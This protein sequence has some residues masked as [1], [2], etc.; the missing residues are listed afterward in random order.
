[1]FLSR[2]YTKETDGKVKHYCDIL[3]LKLD[4]D[5]SQKPEHIIQLENKRIKKILVTPDGRYLVL[6]GRNQFFVCELESKKLYKFY[7]RYA[8]SCLAIHPKQSFVAVGD[9]QGEIVF[10][11]LFE[12]TKSGKFELTPKPVKT[13][14]HWH[15]KVVGDISFD[16]EGVHMYSGGQESVL[17]VWQL[18]TGRRDFLPRLGAGVLGITKTPDETLL[19]LRCDNNTIKI[20]N[21]RNRLLQVNIEGVNIGNQE[22]LL[23]GLVV[24]PRHS[25][26]VFNGMEG[27]L[28]FYSPHE[29][30]H[31]M[32]VQVGFKNP[33]SSF[34]DIKITQSIV[35][36]VVFSHDANWMVT[37]DCRNDLLHESSV[38]FWEWDGEKQQYILHTQYR[39]SQKSQASYI[40]YHPSENI[41]II[42]DKYG[43]FK[44]WKLEVMKNEDEEEDEVNYRWVCQSVGYYRQ[45]EI[46]SCC[47]SQDGS[48]LA[49]AYGSLVTLWNPRSN[50]FLKVLSYTP[51][52]ETIKQMNFVSNSQYLVVFTKC[53]IL[54]WDIIK[55]QLRWAQVISP[56][57]VAFDPRSSKFAVFSSTSLD[58]EQKESN[59]HGC[60]VIYTPEKPNPVGYWI[61]ATKQVKALAFLPSKDA[62]IDGTKINAPSTLTYLN[63]YDE[64]KFLQEATFTSSVVLSKR[65]KKKHRQKI[66]QLKAAAQQ[67]VHLER[68]NS[69]KLSESTSVFQLMYGNDSISQPSPSNGSVSLPRVGARK[70]PVAKMS[71]EQQH[72]SKLTNQFLQDLFQGESHNLPPPTNVYQQFAE[73]LVVKTTSKQ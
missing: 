59:H 62:F 42:A 67:Q 37:L 28:H 49:V 21:S 56:E 53:R 58:A 66:H 25:S 71:L 60:I 5:N 35:Q 34:Q 1:M 50:T 40:C 4:S 30:R 55:C 68:I 61:T 22:R 7:H 69:S 52:F 63:G 54:V 29:D 26:F 13:V 73:F 45:T 33:V 2:S 12:K 32:K 46:T 64:F 31:I 14:Y 20:I 17:V 39:L 48:V 8:I 27:E 65:Q 15:S 41:C 16:D 9:S 38:K 24:E 51:E 43:K 11:H 18:A 57:V 47:F 3:S 70:K 72:A 19:A 6:H 10:Y 44:N 36:S 23:T